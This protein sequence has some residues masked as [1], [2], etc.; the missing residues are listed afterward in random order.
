ME[1]ISE[2]TLTPPTQ[3]TEDRQPKAADIIASRRSCNADGTGLSHYIL[4][5]KTPRS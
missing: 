5:D 4:M 3:T 2:T 1:R